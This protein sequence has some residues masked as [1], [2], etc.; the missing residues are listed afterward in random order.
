MQK[1][2]IELT[3]YTSE[4]G[5]V[6]H[7]DAYV[8]DKTDDGPR[9]AVVICPGG[10]YFA[11][12][13]NWEGE[14]IAMS[15]IAAGFHAIVLNYTTESHGRY[16]CQIKELAATISYCRS[17]AN[18]WQLAPDK[19]A[20]CGF[21]AGGHLAASISTLWNC[22]EIFSVEEIQSELHK[23]N[24]SILCYPVI[25]S[26][27]FAHKDSIINLLG[28]TDE[29]TPNWSL[30]SLENQV[31]ASTP[32]AF[33]WHTVEDTA[34]PVENSILYASALRK[35]HIPFEIH[36]YPKGAHGQSLTTYGIARNKSF[37]PRDYN[38]NK[39]SVDW[40][41]ETFDII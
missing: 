5:F 29:S 19:I 18:E 40:L 23:P 39:L 37:F 36:I 21:S 25:S 12:C 30:M 31:N 38:W 33:L 3:E 7:F 10:G 22:K 11:V 20:V 41:Y 13:E 16:P 2:K 27:E 32:P 6:P 8:L 34:V 14:R 9:P 1:Y 17:M 4:D 35:N 26:G 28:T 15:Y 24:A